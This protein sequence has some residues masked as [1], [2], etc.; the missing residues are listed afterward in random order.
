MKKKD[1]EKFMEYLKERFPGCIENQ[2]TYKL[3]TNLIDYA[4]RGNANRKGAARAIVCC[5]LPEVGLEEMEK[6][7]PDFDEWEPELSLYKRLREVDQIKSV[8]MRRKAEYEVACEFFKENN[9]LL[10][11]E[12]MATV[13][14][15]GLEDFFDVHKA[16]YVTELWIEFGDVSM[17][18]ETECIESEWHGFPVG[19]HREKIWHWFEENFNISI[20]E[21][22][23]G[24]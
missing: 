22:L 12:D 24:L 11:K 23:M 14:S 10:T 2:W 3:I 17:D 5:I 13:K 6:Y 4:Y 8:M 16:S 9:Y 18:P 20:A 1:L 19:T 21:D 7:L 15:R